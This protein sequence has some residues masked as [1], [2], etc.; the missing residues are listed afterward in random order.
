VSLILVG[1][2]EAQG[3]DLRRRQLIE[4]AGVELEDDLGVDAVDAAIAVDVAARLV[5]QRVEEVGVEL[6]DEQ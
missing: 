3:G 1:S 4:E 5:E 6:E 2:P